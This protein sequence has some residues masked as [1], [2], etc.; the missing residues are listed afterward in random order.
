MAPPAGDWIVVR[1]RNGRT[2]RGGGGGARTQRQK[3]CGAAGGSEAVPSDGRGPDDGPEAQA[4]LLEKLGVASGASDGRHSG[5]AYVI[6]RK[7]NTLTVSPLP[8]AAFGVRRRK[9]EASAFFQSFRDQVANLDIAGRLKVPPADFDGAG[10]EA[11]SGARF[12]EGD[13]SQADAAG[14]PPVGGRAASMD[15]VVYGIGSLEHSEVARCQLGLA[16]LLAK[17]LQAALPVWVYD[18]VLTALER[19]AMQCLG[20]ECLPHNEEGL[21]RAERPTVFYMPHCEVELYEN[22]L[23]ANAG[24]GLLGQVAILGNS[25]GHYHL[26]QALPFP[27]YAHFQSHFG[28]VIEFLWSAVPCPNTARPDLLLKLAQSSTHEHPV[29]DGNFPLISAFNDLRCLPRS[30]TSRQRPD[31]AYVFILT[32]MYIP[33]A[34]KSLCEEGSASLSPFIVAVDA[35]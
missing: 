33:L 26:R 12:A 16:G 24:S 31:D 23:L 19:T 30:S 34:S 18:P 20:C 8:L 3:Y 6:G 35:V 13:V 28:T 10:N 2:G 1:R 27:L 7:P 25:F 14:P 15:L 5:R 17:Q 9:V 4:R 29:Q 32:T 21:R 11:T 22:V